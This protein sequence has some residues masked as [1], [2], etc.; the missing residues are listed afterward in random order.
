MSIWEKKR[1]KAGLTRSELAKELNVKE[2][3]IKEVENGQR[4][5]PKSR[6][7]EYLSKI[8][9][10]TPSERKL[11]EAEMKLWFKNLDLKKEIKKFGFANQKQFAKELGFSQSMVSSWANNLNGITKENLTKLYY[12]LNDEFNIR[13]NSSNDINEWY[14]NFDLEGFMNENKISKSQLSQNIRVSA[15]TVGRLLK[16]YP[17]YDKTLLVLKEFVDKTNESKKQE[18]IIEETTESVEK[19]E[20]NVEEITKDFEETEKAEE[21]E[22]MG[23]IE[24]KNIETIDSDIKPTTDLSQ[25]INYEKI[26]LDLNEKLRI[27]NKQIARYET[28]IDLVIK[29]EI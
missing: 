8:N 9:K 1:I 7:D 25:D 28:L 12:Y 26:I 19:I 10:L 3:V 27:A 4:E 14:K 22:E 13:I 20:E 29:K 5:V 15:C 21:I 23:E 2:E 24:E 11:K 16:K 18:Q 6:V 17:A